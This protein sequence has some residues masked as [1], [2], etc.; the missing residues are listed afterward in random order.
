[1]PGSPIYLACTSHVP[2]R[3]SWR[4]TPASGRSCLLLSH[5]QHRIPDSVLATSLFG[6]PA[7]G[8]REGASARLRAHPALLR[9]LNL[10]PVLGLA[11]IWICPL[12]AMRDCLETGKQMTEVTACGDTPLLIGCYLRCYRSGESGSRAAPN[13]CYGVAVDSVIRWAPSSGNQEGIRSGG[14]FRAVRHSGVGKTALAIRIGASSGG[15]V[16]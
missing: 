9:L 2:G 8:L 1:M 7:A 3:R 5:R 16:S 15:S 6:D 13:P 11:A 14:D 12:A 4:E 10:A